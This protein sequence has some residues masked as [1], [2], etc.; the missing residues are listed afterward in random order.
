MVCVTESAVVKPTDF[1]YF[2]YSGALFCSLQCFVIIYLN[3]M[4]QLIQ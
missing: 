2:I 3:L 4:R 1:V